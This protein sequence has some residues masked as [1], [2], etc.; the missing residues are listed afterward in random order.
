[1]YTDEQ[2]TGHFRYGSTRN[3]LASSTSYKKSV[4]ETR[5]IANYNKKFQ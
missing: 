5:Q 3:S 2:Q 1:L 4:L